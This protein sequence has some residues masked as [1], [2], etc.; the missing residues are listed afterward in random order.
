MCSKTIREVDFSYESLLKTLQ[1]SVV[2]KDVFG[3]RLW[4]LKYDAF[5]ISFEVKSLH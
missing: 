2:Q 4:G 1:I 5:S 3:R